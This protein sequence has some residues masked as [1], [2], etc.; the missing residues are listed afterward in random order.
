ML[1][2]ALADQVYAMRA[3]EERYEPQ[4]AERAEGAEGRRGELRRGGGNLMPHITRSSTR[5][6]T[7]PFVSSEVEKPV[8]GE[9]ERRSTHPI[10]FGNSS[11]GGSGSNSEIGSPDRRR[12]A[13]QS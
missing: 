11:G 9:P 1:E 4:G 10:R 8:P 7:P 6:F 13:R 5:C 3:G 12:S 2:Q